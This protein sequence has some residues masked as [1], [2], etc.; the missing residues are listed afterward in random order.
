VTLAQLSNV[1]RRFSGVRLQLPTGR[2]VFGT[3]RADDLLRELETSGVP[4]DQDRDRS[5]FVNGR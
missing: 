4:V 2:I 1:G 3:Y 5:R